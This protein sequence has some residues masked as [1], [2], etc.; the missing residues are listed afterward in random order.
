MKKGIAL[1]FVV[2]SGA[3]LVLST[4]GLATAQDPVGQESISLPSLL[5]TPTVPLT[6]ET[7]ATAQPTEEAVFLGQFPSM[8]AEGTPTPEPVEAEPDILPVE[9]RPVPEGQTIPQ[10]EG[11]NTVGEIWVWTDRGC[12]PSAVYD[13]GDYITFYF[14][15]AQ[16]GSVTLYY[17]K[18]GS[19][20][21]CV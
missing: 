6:R 16:S 1:A 20:S 3:L 17:H 4:F 7:E 2:F 12:G 13:P 14:E 18:P 9:P 19:N 15:A 11:L 21:R 5:S 10:K 8:L